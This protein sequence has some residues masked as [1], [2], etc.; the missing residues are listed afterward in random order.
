MSNGYYSLLAPGARDDLSTPKTFE[1]MRAL[2]T[3]LQAGGNP[4]IHNANPVIVIASKETIAGLL[5]GLELQQANVGENQAEQ[6]PESPF[7]ALL[8][9]FIN[10]IKSNKFL[11]DGMKNAL[12]SIAE[13]AVGI[14]EEEHNMALASKEELKNG[15]APEATNS[16]PDPEQVYDMDA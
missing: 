2:R 3:P 7:Q 5:P 15:K 13:L 8:S 10:S 4:S 6:K 11:P 14:K 12:I 9:K 1:R 16:E